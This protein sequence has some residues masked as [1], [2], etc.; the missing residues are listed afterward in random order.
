MARSGILRFKK[1]K[2]FGKKCAAYPNVRILLCHHIV[3]VLIILVHGTPVY[4]MTHP[5]KFRSMY[6]LSHTK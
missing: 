1:I 6:P 4:K 2:F 5:N 3:C